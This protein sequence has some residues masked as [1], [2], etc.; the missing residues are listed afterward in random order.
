MK[1]QHSRKGKALGWLFILAVT[2]A[3]MHFLNIHNFTPRAALQDWERELG[4]EKTKIIARGEYNEF[5]TAVLS[6]GKDRLLVTGQRYYPLV[7]WQVALDY[8]QRRNDDLPVQVE[9]RAS[10]NEKGTYLYLC[11]WVANPDVEQ[12]D[13]RIRCRQWYGNGENVTDV[14]LT[15]TEFHNW[16]GERVFLL[17]SRDIPVTYTL[18]EVYLLT[19]QGEELLFRA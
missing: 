18:H 1:K 19:E 8:L 17:T 14:Y 16:Q 11:G 2:M 9:G 12:L 3:A 4:I 15:V 10:G 7:G 5:L 6:A 13:L